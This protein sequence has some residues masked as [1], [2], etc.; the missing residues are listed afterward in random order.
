MT[1]TETTVSNAWSTA[2]MGCGL[3]GAV[4]VLLAD[5]PLD[6][7]LVPSIVMGLGF[8]FAL[9]GL[10]IKDEP[11]GTK[12]LVVALGAPVVAAVVGVLLHAPPAAL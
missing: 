6:P 1:T 9:V 12:A 2:A 10:N 11:Q 3:F 8:V 4:A 7:P 5:D